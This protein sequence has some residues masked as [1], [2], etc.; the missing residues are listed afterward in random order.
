M[1]QYPHHTRESVCL[2]KERGE[3]ERGERERE[4]VDR[5]KIIQDAIT[6]IQSPMSFLPPL[7]FL[8]SHLI[9][10]FGLIDIEDFEAS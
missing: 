5:C 10:L 8:K 7:S 1:G 2:E 4:R 9:L 6:G 3:R